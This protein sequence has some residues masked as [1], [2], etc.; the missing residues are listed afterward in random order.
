MLRRF[1][2]NNN[3]NNNNNFNMPLLCY[4]VK[5]F[6]YIPP[7]LVVWGRNASQIGAFASSH[8]SLE[9]LIYVYQAEPN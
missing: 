2:N 3:N 4:K 7:V 9:L 6:L 5:H 8:N 1:N